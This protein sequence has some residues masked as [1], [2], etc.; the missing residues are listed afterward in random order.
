[1]TRKLLATTAGSLPKPNWLAEPETLWPNGNLL[2][3]NC[4]KVNKNLRW[5]GYYNKKKLD[6]KLFLKVNNLEFILY[7]DFFRKFLVSVGTKKS[8]WG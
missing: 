7:M 3:N 6:L 5:N 4:G 1:M 8:K 2:M